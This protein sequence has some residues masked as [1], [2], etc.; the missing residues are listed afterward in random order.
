MEPIAASFLVGF[1][2][3]TVISVATLLKLVELPLSVNRTRAVKILLLIIIASILFGGTYCDNIDAVMIAYAMLAQLLMMWAAAVTFI[4]MLSLLERP[5][6]TRSPRIVM[7][8]HLPA[9]LLTIGVL[10]SFAIPGQVSVHTHSGFVDVHFGVM[11]KAYAI[12]GAFYITSLVFVLMALLRREKALRPDLYAFLFITL[13]ILFALAPLRAFDIPWLPTNA[14]V[15]FFQSL[16][17][18]AMAIALM[19]KSLIIIPRKE[20]PTGEKPKISR[21]AK[22]AN[23]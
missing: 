16:M 8:L 20:K 19:R 9:G 7:L 6:W 18:V 17:G 2:V 12:I 22:S 14:P 1:V 23:S 13:V 15:L 4:L 11:A 21:V 3:T 10:A 5:A